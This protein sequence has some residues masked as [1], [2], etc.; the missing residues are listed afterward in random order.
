LQVIEQ[1]EKGTTQG[2]KQ[3]PSQVTKAPKLK[4]ENGL[5]DW[6]RS[7]EQVCNHIR[8]M[9]P[10]PTPYTFFHRVGKPPLRIIV[11]RAAIPADVLICL[12]DEWVKHKQA[13]GTP[14]MF[15]EADRL[16]VECGEDFG[17]VEILELQPSGKKRM[18]AAEFLRGH[19]L[20]PGDHF[21]PEKE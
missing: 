16:S 3:D 13:P 6:S 2:C 4:K 17:L 7:A 12:P 8:A 5:I 15:P 20:K 1:I 10:W 21:G 18:T 9:L 19:P 14:M 11:N